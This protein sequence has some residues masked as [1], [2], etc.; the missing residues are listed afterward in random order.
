MSALV[1]LNRVYVCVCE[2]LD[3]R[4]KVPGFHFPQGTK[5]RCLLSL[6]AELSS[7]FSLS[8]PSSLLLVVCPPSYCFPVWL[9]PLFLSPTTTTATT[10]LRTGQLRV[11]LHP[12]LFPNPISK[13]GR[14]GS[15]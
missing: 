12:P 1:P 8:L 15:G 6:P 14:W 9:T 4:L 5:D 11:L 2:S 10:A 13:V 7:S 3:S